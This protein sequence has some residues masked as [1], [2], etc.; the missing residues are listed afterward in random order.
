MR[1]PEH[2]DWPDRGERTELE[3]I[4]ERWKW[5]YLALVRGEHRRR[6]LDLGPEPMKLGTA[7]KEFLDH[8]SAHVARSTWSG[9]KTATNHLL[10][11]IPSST[12]TSRITESKLQDMFDRM[13]RKGYRTTTLDTYLRSL[14]V[15]FDWLG[16]HDPTDGVSLPKPVDRDVRTW[17]A[18]EIEAIRKAADQVDAQGIRTFPSCRLAFELSLCLGLRQGEVFAVR[19]EDIDRKSEGARIHS[20]VPKDSTKV[21]HLKGKRARTVFVHP[22]WWGHHQPAVGLICGRDNGRPVGTRTQRNMI[23]RILDTAGLNEVGVGWHAGRHTY[24]RRH[25]EGEGVPPGTLEELQKFL[26]HARMATTE[27]RY[28]HLRDEEA[29]RMARE[30]RMG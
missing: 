3:E 22:D 18:E 20:Q 14:S 24:A 8:R 4:A 2:P 7:I 12:L 5:S 26:G 16:G 1:N 29:L 6:V 27:Q 23:T 30:R 13:L 17:S 19:W 15:F 21:R 25:L 9:D 28:G 11:H 10:D